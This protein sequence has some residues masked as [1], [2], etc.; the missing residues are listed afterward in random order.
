[1]NAKQQR[2]EKAKNDTE[3]RETLYHGIIADAI[4]ES[5]LYDDSSAFDMVSYGQAQNLIVKCPA[6]QA[7]FQHEEGNTAILDF[8]SFKY[9]GGGY[10]TGAIAQEEALCHASI[11]YN[12]LRG[13]DKIYAWNRDHTNKGLYSNR[14]LFVKDVIFFD[15]D[16]QKSCSVIV[17]AAPNY[18]AA[19]KYN[20]VSIEENNKALED[21]IRLIM[22][23]AQDNHIDT[24]I[25]G[26]F[27]CGVFG[28]DAEQVANLFKQMSKNTSIKKIV[29]ALP[30]F[31]NNWSSYNNYHT[32]ADVFGEGEVK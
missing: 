2:A 1:M 10:I 9:P 4:T 27:G 25:A 11:L 28:Q 3:K 19:T 32:F 17:C 6:E 30:V 20:R 5:R 23:T 15:D 12:I 22:Q 8:A 26:A 13:F 14:A 31:E 18:D 16:R 24:L 21:R 7:L 29:Y